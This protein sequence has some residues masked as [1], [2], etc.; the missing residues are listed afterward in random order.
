MQIR[1]VLPA[2]ALFVLLAALPAPVPQPGPRLLPARSIPVP[3]TVS[4]ILQRRIAEPIVVAPP[5]P[6]TPAAIKKYIASS[7]ASQGKYVAA[8]LRRFPAKVVRQTIGGVP[9]YLVTPA[10]LDRAF[11]R[12]LLVHVHGGAYALY[13][14]FAALGEAVFAAHYTRTPVLSID[15]RMPPDHPFPAARDDTVAVWRELVRD[16]NPRAMALFGTSAGGGLTLAAVQR[17]RALGLPLPGALFVGTPWADLARDDDTQFTNQ[18]LDDGLSG[19]DLPSYAR[20]YAAGRD[21]ND[22]GISPIRGDFHHFPP[23]ILISGTRDLLLSTT[24]RTHRKMRKAG[25]IADLNVFEALSH[26]EYITIAPESAEAFGQV[27]AFF[28]RYLSR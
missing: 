16:H 1:F 24:V 23:T 17:F 11:H 10:T 5:L 25:V 8:L 20:L 22:P 18:G 2:A 9:V 28:D 12:R 19:I 26:A 7:D 4:R 3:T 27:A 6:S 15:Y 13:G 21:L 14:G